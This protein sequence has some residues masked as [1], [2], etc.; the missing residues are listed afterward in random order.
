[1]ISRKRFS[2][3]GFT[4]GRTVL[5][6][7]RDLLIMTVLLIPWA[8]MWAFAQP[9]MSTDPT[10]IGS[11]AAQAN[12]INWNTIILAFFGLIT[13]LA[14]TFGSIYLVKMGK[15]VKDTHTLVNS[16]MGVQ[17][18]LGMDLADFKAKTTGI[19]EDIAAA[20]LARTRYQEHV[21]KQAIVDS[22][23]GP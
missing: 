11:Q 5:I 15:V 13:S 14:T 20:T 16:N 21:K 3:F 19:P 4:S 9:P 8:V 17:L 22:G 2:V 10:T 6:G 18:L 7:F 1:M 23:V 12:T